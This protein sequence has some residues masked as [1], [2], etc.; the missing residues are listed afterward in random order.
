M[1]NGFPRNQKRCGEGEF[2]DG[3]LGHLSEDEA[4]P[5]LEW[6]RGCQHDAHRLDTDR[7]YLGGQWIYCFYGS[8]AAY[9]RSAS[10]VASP[11]DG[12]EHL[13]L[14]LALHP[15]DVL[16]VAGRQASSSGVVNA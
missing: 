6:P 7:F 8:G 13:F 2:C 10:G 12:T 1:P 15:N 9:L 14:Q 3:A 11:S 4:R 16:I 5:E